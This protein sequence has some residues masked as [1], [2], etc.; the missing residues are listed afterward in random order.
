MFCLCRQPNTRKYLRSG[1]HKQSLCS[2]VRLVPGCYEKAFQFVLD[3][4]KCYGKSPNGQQRTDTTGVSPQLTV[5]QSRPHC[6]RRFYHARTVTGREY[7]CPLCGLWRNRELPDILSRHFSLSAFRQ[8]VA[9]RC[10]RLCSSQSQRG[11]IWRMDIRL[12]RITPVFATQSKTGGRN[13]I[14]LTC[15]LT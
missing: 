2:F 5:C 7:H 11:S 9:Y 15:L 8:V 10:T 1:E 12:S 4:P 13:L 14:P 3:T 6:L